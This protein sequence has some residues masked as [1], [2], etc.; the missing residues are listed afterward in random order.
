VLAI[1]AATSVWVSRALAQ[2][3]TGTTVSIESV[4]YCGEGQVTVTVKLSQASRG[5]R[6]SPWRTILSLDANLLSMLRILTYP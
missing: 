6:K 3:P 4:K 2:P 1:L 5:P